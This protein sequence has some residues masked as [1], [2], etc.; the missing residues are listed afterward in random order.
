MDQELGDERTECDQCDRAEREQHPGA[1]SPIAGAG[2][3]LSRR[4]C[5]RGRR[6]RRDHER[7]ALAC[8]PACRSSVQVAVGGSSRQDLGRATV[9]GHRRVR[10]PRPRARAA[11]A[12]ARMGGARD[13]VPNGRRAARRSGCAR[14]SAIPIAVVARCAGR[15][16]G[17]STPRTSRGRGS[18]RMN[19]EGSAVVA[20]AVAACGSCTSRATSSSTAPRPLP[21]GGRPGA[22]QLVRP[23]E[24]GGGAAGRGSY[25]RRRRSCARRSSTA[26]PSRARRSGS[27]GTTVA[28]SSTRSV[29]RSRS[30]ILRTALLELLELDGAGAAARRRGR[31]RLAL[32]LRRAARRRSGADRGGPDDTRSRAERV[33]RQL[34]GASMLATR[35]RG[36]Y[37]VLSLAPEPSA[38]P[39]LRPS[40]VRRKCSSGTCRSAAL[41]SAK[42][43]SPSRERGVDVQPPAA[44]V[45]EPRADQ[46]LGVDRHRDGGSGRRSA[47]SRPGTR[48]RWRAGRPP[49]PARPRRCRRARCPGRP[50]GARRTRSTPRTRSGPPR[51]AA[52]GAGRSGC[53]RSPSTRIM[54][55]RESRL[56]RARRSRTSRSAAPGRSGSAPRRCGQVL[57][58]VLGEERVVGLGRLPAVDHEVAVGLLDVVQQLRADVP[59]PAEELR[60]LAVGAVTPARSASRRR[61]A[62]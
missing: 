55:R 38:R 20:E 48:T 33:P 19:V 26:A 59:A 51:P 31:R 36:V 43:S 49:R 30:A 47:P 24:G 16:R 45:V 28:S 2:P 39:Q 7:G 8:R 61:A 13:L 41:H 37:E 15:R 52:A 3:A 58:L 29:R 9:I 60:P 5:R 56:I 14:T 42:T 40:G 50:D 17:R 21:R 62:S 46:Q 27:R 44:V 54:M 32:R 34:A 4:E 11:R 6:S 35:V 53:R 23:L 1:D 18:G 57:G 22:G 25:I 10:V 12:R